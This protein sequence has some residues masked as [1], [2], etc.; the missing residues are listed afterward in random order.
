MAFIETLYTDIF[1]RVLGANPVSHL[2]GSCCGNVLKVVP[3]ITG[4][5]LLILTLLRMNSSE[6]SHGYMEIARTLGSPSS[7]KKAIVSLK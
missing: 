5:R 6:D 3:W 7:S 2:K 1:R 4:P